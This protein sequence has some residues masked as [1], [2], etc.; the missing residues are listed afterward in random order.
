MANTA[1]ISFKL[2]PEEYL[3]IQGLAFEQKITIN[4]LCRAAVRHALQTE[5]HLQD[6]H[7]EWSDTRYEREFLEKVDPD[8]N[9]DWPN[10]LLK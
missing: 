9:P 10:E 1:T 5:S 3:M 2:L 4:R 6:P 7:A 8:L